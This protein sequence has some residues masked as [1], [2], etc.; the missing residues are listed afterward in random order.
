M[1]EI[2]AMSRMEDHETEESE[3]V[4]A[5]CPGLTPEKQIHIL[6]GDAEEEL[7]LLC[8]PTTQR[9][10]ERDHHTAYVALHNIIARI[11]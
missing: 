5:L 11:I 10:H 7:F 1:G 8:D 4:R 9:D 6:K 2:D 3:R